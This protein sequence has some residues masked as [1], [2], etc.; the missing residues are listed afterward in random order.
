MACDSRETVP[1]AGPLDAPPCVPSSAIPKLDLLF[2][3]ETSGNWNFGLYEFLQAMDFQALADANGELPDLHVGVITTNVGG[4]P[5]C[6]GTDGDGGRLQSHPRLGDC[7]ARPEAFVRYE[8]LPDGSRLANFAEPTLWK[9][10]TCRMWSG[11]Q[12]CGF[13]QPLEAVYRALNGSVPENEGFLRD[14][15]VLGVVMWSEQDDCSAIDPD[16]YDR[17]SAEYGPFGSFRCTEYGVLCGDPP[18]PIPRAPGTYA[19]CIP[20]D[21][22]PALSH[23]QRVVDLLRSLKPDSGRLAFGL[24]AFEPSPL[25]VDYDTDGQVRVEVVCEDGGTYTAVSPSI[26][27]HHVIDQFPYRARGRRCEMPPTPDHVAELFRPM[28]KALYCE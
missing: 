7:Q 9:A 2:V 28:R 17:E 25:V 26:R 19:S 16:L 14:D 20:R 27:L 13:D 24:W 6:P 18:S 12:G 4:N 10:V 23:P 15:A 22:V 5:Y 21:D 1:D 11:G 3:I 8:V